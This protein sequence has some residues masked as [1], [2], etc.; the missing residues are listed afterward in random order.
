[1][2]RALFGLVVLLAGCPSPVCPTLATRCDGPRVE[3]CA[4]DGQWQTVADCEAAG[5]V[6]QYVHDS[7][8]DGHVCTWGGE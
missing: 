7:E 5:G 1:M 4:S 8:I 3:T 6:C 2:M